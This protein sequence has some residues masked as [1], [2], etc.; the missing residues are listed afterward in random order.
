MTTFNQRGQ[1]IN[2]NQYNI[3]GNSVINIGEVPNALQLLIQEIEHAEKN[4]SLTPETATGAKGEVQDAIAE[5]KKPEPN[6]KLIV[7][8][9]NGAKALIEGLA[10][11]TGLVKVLVEA[12]DMVRRLIP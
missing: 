6:S 2:G 8:K 11:A 9:L 3:G 7:G 4:G 10:S 1:K 5:A 12:V